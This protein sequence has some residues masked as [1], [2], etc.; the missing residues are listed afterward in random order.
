MTVPSNEK[1]IAMVNGEDNTEQGKDKGKRE[2]SEEENLETSKRTKK[3]ETPEKPLEKKE[4]SNVVFCGS[5][6]DERRSAVK[7]MKCWT[8]HAL[9]LHISTHVLDGCGEF[10]PDPDDEMYCDACD[11][12]RS[13]HEKVESL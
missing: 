6:I 1:T 7:Y 8:N 3:D 10:V 5:S 4:T 12:H 2:R 11:C 13:F 9:H